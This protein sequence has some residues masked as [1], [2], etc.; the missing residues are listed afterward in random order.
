MGKSLDFFQN[1]G[2][3]DNVSH[4]AAC[5]YNCCTTD[6]ENFIVLFPWEMDAAIKAGLNVEHLVPIKDN[7]LYVHCN[8]PCTRENDYKPINCAA[9]PLY[10]ISEDLSAW[11]RGA[12][13]RC[14]ISDIRLRGQIKVIAD[15]LRKIEAQHPGSIKML[16]DFIKSYPGE[17][18]ELEVC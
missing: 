16:V 7:S 10:P 6:G 3:I 14:P 11:V 15:G 13:S 5:K 4:C 12:K 18:E 9:Y 1:G 17:L 2:Q 8:R